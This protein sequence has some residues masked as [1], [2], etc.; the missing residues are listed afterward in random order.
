[1]SHADDGRPSGCLRFFGR[2]E[3]PKDSYVIYGSIVGVMLYTNYIYPTII[4]T[5]YEKLHGSIV[6]DR[7]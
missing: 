4:I 6:G 3:P 7:L 2:W 5:N 1:M